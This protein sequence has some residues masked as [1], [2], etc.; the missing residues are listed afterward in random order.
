MTTEYSIVHYTCPAGDALFYE[1]GRITVSLPFKTYTDEETTLHLAMS[2]GIQRVGQGETSAAAM[3]S[4]GE[5]LR[6]YLQSQHWNGKLRNIFQKAPWQQ[7]GIT[8][9]RADRLVTSWRERPDRC[10]IELR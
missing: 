8:T 6:A 1:D 5:I 9:A 10:L 3:R 4:L 7:E 2:G